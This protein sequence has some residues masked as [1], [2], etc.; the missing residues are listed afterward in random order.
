MIRS[1]E[2]L[3]NVPDLGTV[4]ATHDPLA[5]ILMQLKKTYLTGIRMKL[6]ANNSGYCG[7]LI[8]YT[9]LMFSLLFLGIKYY[10]AM[11]FS[12]AIKKEHRS[13]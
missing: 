4:V 1:G 5:K 7:T 8:F 12:V 9:I 6:K 3:I 2:Y 10:N 11:P 13:I